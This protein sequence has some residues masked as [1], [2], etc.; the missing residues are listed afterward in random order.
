[1]PQIVNTIL[2]SDSISLESIFPN[3]LSDSEGSEVYTRKASIGTFQEINIIVIKF[4]FYKIKKIH[5]LL[6]D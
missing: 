4:L 1:M 2:N 6:K 3:V 5:C